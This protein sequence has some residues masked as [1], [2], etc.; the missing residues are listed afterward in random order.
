MMLAAEISSE[1]SCHRGWARPTQSLVLTESFALFGGFVSRKSC[2]WLFVGGLE[3]MAKW[4]WGET[5][6]RLK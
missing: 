2:L 4:T 6:V 5:V 3:V 1:E